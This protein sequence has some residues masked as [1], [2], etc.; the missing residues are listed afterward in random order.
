MCASQNVQTLKGDESNSDAVERSRRFFFTFYKQCRL[1]ESLMLI[2][3]LSE[4]SDFP[5]SPNQFLGWDFFCSFLQ[6]DGSN[7]D[8]TNLLIVVCN[9]N[10]ASLPSTSGYLTTFSSKRVQTFPHCLWGIVADLPWMWMPN[11]VPIKLLG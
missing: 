7:N 11:F 9:C 4:P 2:W 3:Y 5:Y 6:Q 8:P 10:Q 1:R